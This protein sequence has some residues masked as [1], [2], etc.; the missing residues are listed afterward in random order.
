[1]WTKPES[2]LIH[3][4]AEF[5]SLTLPVLEAADVRTVCEIGSEHGGNTRVLAEW[6]APRGGE[7]TCIDPAPAP[8]F[9]SWL[10]ERPG[11]RHLR[12]PSLK[13]LDTIDAADAWFVDG[14]HNWYTVYRELVEIRSRCCEQGAPFLVFMHDIGWPC[15]RRDMYYAPERIPPQYRHPHSWDR[16]VTLGNAGTIDGGFRGMG[17]FACALHE[18]GPRN[19]TLTAVED[20]A[21]G[22]PEAFLFASIPAVFGLGVLFERSHPHAQAIATLL[23]PFHDNPLLEKLEQSRLASYLEVIA[24]QD[25]DA[26][27]QAAREEQAA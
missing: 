2:L 18:G 15:A 14:D 5:A 4:M 24:W 17:Q 11:V 16:G 26:A 12:Q 13:A 20:F 8:E 10:R 22:E 25:R 19:G 7:L 1:M 9:L 3:S 23:A 27:R 6:L 21:A